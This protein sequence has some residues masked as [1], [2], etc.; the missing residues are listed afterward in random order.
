MDFG[1]KILKT[2]EFENATIKKCVSPAFYTEYEYSEKG[3]KSHSVEDDG[4]KIWRP[5]RIFYI[6]ILMITRE[7]SFIQNASTIPK[8]EFWIT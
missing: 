2:F 1:K 6:N 8:K 7:E 5:G 4:S 3:S